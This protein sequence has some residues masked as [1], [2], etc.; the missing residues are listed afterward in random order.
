MSKGKW[1][2]SFFIAE[3]DH[4]TDAFFRTEAE[5]QAFYDSLTT[6]IW[7]GIEYDAYGALAETATHIYN[8]KVS[9]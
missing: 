8:D 2:V 6:A 1:V 3:E 7:Q 4:M 9:A 5:A